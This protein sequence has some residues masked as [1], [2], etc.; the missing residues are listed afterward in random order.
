MFP[1]TIGRG[2]RLLERDC[3]IAA[4]WASV[5]MLMTRT[6][7]R[8]FWAINAPLCDYRPIIDEATPRVKG[9]YRKKGRLSTHK[10]THLFQETNAIILW[11]A[12]MPSE[13]PPA[14]RAFKCTFG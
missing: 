5:A 12:N 3:G 11:R 6:P 1:Q 13:G 9:D 8:Q 7:P 4:L 2:K 10:P 14:R